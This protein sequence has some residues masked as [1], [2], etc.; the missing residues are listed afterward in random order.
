[1]FAETMRLYEGHQE[2]VSRKSSLEVVLTTLATFSFC[3]R[4]L[5]PMTLTFERD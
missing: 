4:E 5:R 2:F 1:M 3:V